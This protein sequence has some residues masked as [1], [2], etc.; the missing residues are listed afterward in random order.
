MDAL[1]VYRDQVKQ[2]ASLGPGVIMQLS[3]QL[4]DD[5]LPEHGISLADRKPGEPALWS[6]VDKEQL[7]AER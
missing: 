2:A 1:A 6:F 7:L 5:V 3:D 4:R